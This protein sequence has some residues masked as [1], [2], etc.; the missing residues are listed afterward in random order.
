[1]AYIKNTNG[2]TVWVSEHSRRKAPPCKD[3]VGP[4]TPE[5]LFNHIPLTVS[6]L[7]DS[8]GKPVVISVSKEKVNKD[9]VFEENGCRIKKLLD[10]GGNT[11]VSGGC[12]ECRHI[13]RYRSRETK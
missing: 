10:E 12:P 13:V 8:N 2:E 6:E 1:M 4:L 11:I 3:G 5:D 9:V 7:K